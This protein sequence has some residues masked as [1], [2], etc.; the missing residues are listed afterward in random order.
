MR[1]MLKSCAAATVLAAAACSLAP[2]GAVAGPVGLSSQAGVSL[3]SPTDKAAWICHRVH[4]RWAHYGYAPRTTVIVRRSYYGYARP[5]Y[6]AYSHPAYYAYSHPVYY[7]YSHPA[8][9]AYSRPAY[10]GYSRPS[11]CGYYGY[12]ARPAYYGSA[13]CSCNTCGSGYYG[14][15]YPSASYGSA[16]PGYY[17]WGGG[18]GAGLGAAALGAATLPFG[19]F[20]GWGW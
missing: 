8:Y 14:S 6:Y 11:S 17:G 3:A 1:N 4:R 13:G 15:A 2:E 20:G 16:Y 7:A 12:V 9:Y 18:L 5:A 10:Y 19:L